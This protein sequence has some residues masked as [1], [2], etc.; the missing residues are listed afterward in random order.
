MTARNAATIGASVAVAVVVAAVA[1]WFYLGTYKPLRALST[2]YAPGAGIGA[3]VQ[4]VTGS[5]GRPVFFPAI[6]RRRTFDAAFTLHNSGRFSVTVTGLA[7]TTQT[8]APWIGPAKLLATTSGTVS[9][10]ERDLLPFRR[11][12]LAPGDDAIVVVR[13]ALRCRGATA[14]DPDA[15]AGDVRL[16]YTYLSI[17]T[18]T[19]KVRLPFAVTLR[20]VGGPPASP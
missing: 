20:C 16:R 9:A 19:A 8:P 5:G 4:P 1:L 14:A 2:D 12:K 17:F 18:R 3:D 6:G 11:L 13:F 10:A 15:V 7:A